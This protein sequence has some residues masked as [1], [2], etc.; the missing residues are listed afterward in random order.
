M[1]KRQ[2][3]IPDAPSKSRVGQLP[4]G[5]RFLI[6]NQVIAERLYQRDPLTIGLSKDGVVFERANSI[7]W[8]SPRFKVPTQQKNDGRG[9]GLQYPDFEIHDGFLWVIYSV[10]K[11]CVDVSRIPIEG[12]SLFQD[13]SDGDRAA[14]PK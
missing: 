1:Y 4:D 14:N 8:K 11:E 12:I 7:R 2:T 10:N 3:Q 6:G 5:T 9:W 13:E